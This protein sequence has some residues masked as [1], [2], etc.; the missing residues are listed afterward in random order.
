M[1]EKLSDLALA[2]RLDSASG[3]ARRGAVIYQTTRN[4]MIGVGLTAA[5]FLPLTASNEQQEQPEKTVIK[6]LPTQPVVVTSELKVPEE[7]FINATPDIDVAVLTSPVEGA[8]Q[9]T[10]AWHR[11]TFSETNDEFW[12]LPDAQFIL[13]FTRGTSFPGCAGPTCTGTFALTDQDGGELATISVNAGRTVTSDQCDLLRPPVVVTE[14]LACELPGIA[15]GGADVCL[16]LRPSQHPEVEPTFT[17]SGSAPV[18]TLV[19]DT[20]PL[21]VRWIILR[22]DEESCPDY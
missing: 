14:T 8:S 21:D 19:E 4:M 2:H 9:M 5:V 11:T 16:W 6:L 12:A 17:P 10:R 15:S 13:R 20:L 1:S 18:R 7:V 3:L 22:E